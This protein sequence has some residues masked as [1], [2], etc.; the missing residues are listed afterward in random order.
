MSVSEAIELKEQL[1][2][3]I[4]QGFVCP[5]VSPWSA[6]VLFNKKKDGTLRLC[7]DYRGLNPATVK[8]KYPIP[9]MD[10]LLDRLQGSSIYT[11]IDLKSGYYQIRVKDED[12]SK[13][14]FNTRY[15]H[16]EFIVIPF[17]LT[18]APATFNRLM[19]EIFREHLD[20]FVLVFFDAILVYSKNEEEHE[21]HVRRVFQIL[22][23]NQLYAKR[24]KCTFFTEKVE[25]LGFIVSKDGV[26]T[27]PTKI[28]AVLN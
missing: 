21:Q 20:D 19:S 1:T 25:Y 24:S 2:Q 18:N 6:P 15:G 7:I 3:L 26:S 28:E 23:Q 4:D 12:I 13:T 5:S 16:Y 9:R 27:D 17:G 22:R 8:N 10:E 11:K 14:G